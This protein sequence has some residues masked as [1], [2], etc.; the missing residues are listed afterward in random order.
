M[1]SGHKGY[2]SSCQYVPDEDTHD[3]ITSSGDHTCILWDITTGPRTSV[4]G[5]EFQSGHTVDVLSVSINGSNSRMFVSGSCDATAR[6]WD[7]RIFQMA[8]DLELVQNMELA[9]YLTLEWVTNSKSRSWY[10]VWVEK[11]LKPI[12]TIPLLLFLDIP[13]RTGGSITTPTLTKSTQERIYYQSVPESPLDRGV[14]TPVTVESL[15]SDHEKLSNSQ[16]IVHQVLKI[17]D[18]EML[19]DLFPSL[20]QQRHEISA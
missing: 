16:C 9:D 20:C 17:L 8:P 2:V 3:L 5:G 18:V 13:R 6:Q 12:V 11:D 1:L 4:F 10:W 15:E 14:G 19:L 7:T